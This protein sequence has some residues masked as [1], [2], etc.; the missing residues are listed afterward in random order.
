MKL[1]CKQ[2]PSDDGR[3]KSAKV[4]G[5]AT[6]VSLTSREKKCRFREIHENNRTASD[7]HYPI[8]SSHK[9]WKRDPN[10]VGSVCR[11]RLASSGG[12]K[13]RAFFHGC[14]R[15]RWQRAGE[16]F[17]PTEMLFL[18][19]RIVDYT[20]LYLIQLR[21]FILFLTSTLPSVKSK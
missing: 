21:R 20:N 9:E 6:S 5:R 10:V 15:S 16:N 18:K 19:N 12:L 7:S 2:T 1:A 4:I 14:S 8:R 17:P 11:H 3:K 13:I